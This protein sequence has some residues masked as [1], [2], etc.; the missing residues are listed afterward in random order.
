MKHLACCGKS[1]LAI[2]AIMV[3][4]IALVYALPLGVGLG[5]DVLELPAGR[6]VVFALW[7]VVGVVV[8]RRL[9]R[10]LPLQRTVSEHRVA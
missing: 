3:S 10:Q 6:L 1:L 2:V 7:G 5:L 4:P 9:L 8:L